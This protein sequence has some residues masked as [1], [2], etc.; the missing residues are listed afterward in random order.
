VRGDAIAG[1]AITIINL[2]GGVA[3]GTMR[4]GME[5]GESLEL[6]GRLTVGDGLLAQIPAL[7][8]SLAAGVLV[9]RV[10]EATAR[11]GGRWRGSSRRC[12]RCRRRC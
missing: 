6:Y 12:W 9:T 4:H 3:V 7:L 11:G 10:D 5:V 1:L 2:A 8:V